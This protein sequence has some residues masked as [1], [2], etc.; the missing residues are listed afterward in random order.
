MLS[1]VVYG[2]YEYN[3]IIFGVNV[4]SQSLLCVPIMQTHNEHCVSAV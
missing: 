3:E 2:M 4:V 1:D